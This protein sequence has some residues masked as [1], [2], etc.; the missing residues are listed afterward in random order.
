MSTWRLTKVFWIKRWERYRACWRFEKGAE[1]CPWRLFE[2]QRGEDKS[3]FLTVETEKISIKPED[4]A[5]WK[6]KETSEIERIRTSKTEQH[7]K[8]DNPVPHLS[9]IFFTFKKN[10]TKYSSLVKVSQR[11]PL[12]R[13]ITNIKSVKKAS[14]KYWEAASEHT[15]IIEG[16][17]I[18]KREIES[19]GDKVGRRTCIDDWTFWSTDEQ[20]PTAQATTWRKR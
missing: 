5:W 4:R 8:T 6:Y 7:S 9:N 3:K 1:C 19:K 18:I 13:K 20:N 2:G 12:P 16:I 15:G 17:K 11:N 14:I 10:R